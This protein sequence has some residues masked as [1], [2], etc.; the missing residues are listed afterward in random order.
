MATRVR[1][2]AIWVPPLQ[3]QESSRL[4]AGELQGQD[5]VLGQGTPDHRPLPGGP[6]QRH[7]N[8]RTE[9]VLEWLFI[10]QEQPKTTQSRGPLSFVDVFVDFTW[11]EWRLLDPSQKHLYRSVMLENYSNLVSLGYQDSKPDIIFKL[12]QEEPW[13]MPA[14]IPRPG[15]PDSTIP[16]S[17]LCYISRSLGSSFTGNIW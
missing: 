9:Q 14:Q 4:R 11:E 13:M 15:H 6:W 17:L 2:A 7:K 1:T 3:E 5:T 16:V 8:H 12:E 10:S